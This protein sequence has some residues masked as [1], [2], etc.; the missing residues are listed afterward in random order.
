MVN[1]EGT[2]DAD[3]LVVGVVECW[4]QDGGDEAWFGDDDVLLDGGNGND[5]GCL[6]GGD[7][8][9]VCLDN[10]DLLVDDNDSVDG[11]FEKD[12]GSN[13]DFLSVLVDDAV[14]ADKAAEVVTSGELEFFRLVSVDFDDDTED[15]ILLA[16]V[17]LHKLLLPL[18]FETMLPRE[19][20][21]MRPGKFKSNLFLLSLLF[22][23]D[24]CKLL[25][26]PLRILLLME[27]LLSVLLLSL[28]LLSLMT[29]EFK[30]LV[31]ECEVNKRFLL[32]T[33]LL[34]PRLLTNL[35]AFNSKLLLEEWILIISCLFT[36]IS[37]FP[38]L[39]LPSILSLLLLPILCSS[40]SITKIP[41]I[42]LQS[43]SLFS[44][45]LVKVVFLTF[46]FLLVV[47]VIVVSLLSPFKS[48]P[49]PLIMP[50]FGSTPS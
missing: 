5:V 35:L 39:F 32:I 38:L 3:V 40:S 4:V 22:T 34:M 23:V 9:D 20:A 8:D 43:S 28:I 15:E 49:Y 26:L 14:F 37:M 50:S 2:L 17:F 31:S 36:L 12:V 46:L 13:D 25:T 48:S 29:R 30:D 41:G 1:E 42:T 45:P 33:L 44:L 19:E 47:V 21:L 11:G 6:D 7:D 10:L 16:D 24:E 27:I 18:L